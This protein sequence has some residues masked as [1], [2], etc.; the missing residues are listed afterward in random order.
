MCATGLTRVCSHGYGGLMRIG[1]CGTKT[2][3]EYVTGFTHV[4]LVTSIRAN[5]HAW[6]THAGCQTT[7]PNTRI[8]LLHSA[9]AARQAHPGA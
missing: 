8:V 5:K 2:S 6:S 1:G 9:A 3:R 4:C 7:Q